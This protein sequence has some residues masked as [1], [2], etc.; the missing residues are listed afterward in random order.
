MESKKMSII[1]LVALT[2]NICYSATVVPIPDQAGILINPN[3]N[4]KNCVVNGIIEGTEECDDGDDDNK[5]ECSNQCNINQGWT[6]IEKTLLDENL[7]KS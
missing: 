1:I 2:F 7:S 6:C 4:L 5:N 3:K